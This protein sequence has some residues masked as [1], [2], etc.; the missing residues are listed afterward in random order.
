LEILLLFKV[1]P[2]GA[3]GFIKI[4]AQRITMIEKKYRVLVAD[5]PYAYRDANVGG[6]FKSGSC[7]HYTVMTPETIA[8]MRVQDIMQDNSVCFLWITVPLLPHGVDILEKWG[9]SYRTSLFWYKVDP[10]T[11]RGRLG[12]GRYFRGMIEVCL[13]GIRGEI[14]PFA[15]QSQ[16]VIREKPRKHSQKPEGFWTLI[17]HALGEINPHHESGFVNH[18]YVVDM[19]PEPR[20]ELFCRGEPRPYWDGWG[21]ECTGKRKV[22]LDIL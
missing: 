1:N 8:K 14:K 18:H 21:N 15:C 19:N 17:E 6:S 13:V 12:L 5:P 20:I 16:N 11:H 2:D 22:E 10:E 7:Q 9:Y 3:D 4:P